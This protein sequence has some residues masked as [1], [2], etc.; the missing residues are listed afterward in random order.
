MFS[1]HARWKIKLL[2]LYCASFKEEKDVMSPTDLVMNDDDEG[3]NYDEKCADYMLNGR[4]KYTI[5]R[6]LSRFKCFVF[7]LPWVLYG[8]VAQR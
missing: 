4:V 2:I 5:I 6:I 3:C 8:D 7:V 1:F